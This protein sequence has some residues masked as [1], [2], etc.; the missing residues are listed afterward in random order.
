MVLDVV[1]PYL[2]GQIRGGGTFIAYN[3][4]FI[5]GTAVAL[6]L[7]FSRMRFSSRRTVACISW[8][9]GRLVQCLC[10]ALQCFDRQMVFMGCL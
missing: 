5:V 4:P 6:F 8:L 2:I 9:G 1:S 3:S 10:A 7:I